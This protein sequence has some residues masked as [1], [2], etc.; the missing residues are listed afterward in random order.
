[1]RKMRKIV[2]ILFVLFF[3]MLFGET[4]TL[5]V[6]IGHFDD[7]NIIALP[8]AIKDARAF[9]DTLLSLSIVD[10]ENLLYYEN[11]TLSKLKKA[12]ISWVKMAKSESDLL[13]F[14]YSGHGYSK[15]GKTYLI[16]SDA[17]SDVLSETA[18]DFT[19]FLSK[20]KP[21]IKTKKVLIILDS[22]YSGS[23]IKDRPVKFKTYEKKTLKDLSDS[24]IFLLSSKEGEVS[25]EK[26]GGGGWF[27]HYLIEGVRGKANSN[28]DDIVTLEE[29]YK[30]VSENVEKVTNGMQHPVMFASSNMEDIPISYDFS[31][32]EMKALKEL[33]DR[34][35]PKDVLRVTSKVVF[36]NP[37]EDDELD[38][39]VR[40]YIHSFA[41]G[42]IDYDMY[43]DLI[44]GLKLSTSP[45]KITPKVAPK[46]TFQNP[47]AK[48]N[49]IVQAK[50]SKKFFT[51]GADLGT[52]LILPFADAYIK[53]GSIEIGVGGMIFPSE[54]PFLPL[55]KLGLS[56]NLWKMAFKIGVYY[57]E[58]EETTY[59]YYYG[60][61]SET[62]PLPFIYAL[63]S[64]GSSNFFF[65][66]SDLIIPTFLWNVE[67]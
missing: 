51:V 39:K 59:D 62:T 41:L 67:F 34:G 3:S 57:G 28:G 61:S 31:M 49:E 11:P 36:Q 52:F 63:V 18:L 19:E 55:V 20:V 29:L 4:Y 14:Y 22:C 5:I 60:Y 6:G 25:Q 40:N 42:K 37:V 44:K 2:S 33:K 13:I 46:S 30:Y 35:A 15:D 17:Y 45:A 24:V 38:R 32:L 10:K 50:E 43:I 7:K 66:T 8:G 56:T 21:L 47:P 1:M 26:R 48:S 53:I 12:I 58:Y 27:T 64:F 9:K 16:P 65:G 54:E 23:L